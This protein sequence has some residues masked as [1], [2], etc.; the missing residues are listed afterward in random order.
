MSAPDDRVT[1]GRLAELAAPGCLCVNCEPGL[2]GDVR[3]LVDE[4]SALRKRVAELEAL[5]EAGAR[6][7]EA[8]EGIEQR[9]AALLRE[10]LELYAS[11]E[12]V[13]ATREER[14]R[15]DEMR[16]MVGLPPLDEKYQAPDSQP[17]DVVRDAAERWADAREDWQLRQTFS[18]RCKLDDAGDELVAVLRGQPVPPKGERLAATLEALAGIKGEN[19]E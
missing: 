12:C 9:S 11:A 5:N 18:S 7:V 6:A 4:V 16:A 15:V 10:A 13:G 14:K 3:L 19:D 8:L 1:A 2:A 17:L